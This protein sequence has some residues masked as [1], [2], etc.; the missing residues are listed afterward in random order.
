[1]PAG[2][3]VNATV[4]GSTG[5]VTDTGVEAWPLLA[6]AVN[7]VVTVEAACPDCSRAAVVGANVNAP[8]EFTVTV[9]LA[10]WLVTL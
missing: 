1:M 6:A 7:D 2:L 9:P 4:A 10:G 8:V 5:T 3:P